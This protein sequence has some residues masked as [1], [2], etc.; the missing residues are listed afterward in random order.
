VTSLAQDKGKAPRDAILVAKPGQ[1][2]GFPACTWM[3][4]KQEKQCA[5]KDEPAIFLPP[6]AAPTGIG[7]IGKTLYVD[8]FGGTGKGPEVVEMSE[9][10]QPRPFLTGFAAPV[11][12]LGV[13][14]GNIYVGDLTGSIY[15][16]AAK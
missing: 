6:H 8:L 11:V 9:R 12:A 15:R 1:D 5:G 14:E 10:G 7:S 2:Y 16:V 4:P 13:N 3:L